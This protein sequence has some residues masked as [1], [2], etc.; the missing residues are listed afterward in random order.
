[1]TKKS[2]YPLRSPA[3]RAR[4]IAMLVDGRAPVDVAKA[5]RVSREA[6][7]QFAQRHAAEIEQLQA[8][9]VAAV[10]DATITQQAERIRRRDAHYAEL[11]KIV[12]WR[13]AAGYASGFLARELKSVTV[14]DER[15]GKGGDVQREEQEVWKT[16]KALADALG[17]ELR[18]VAEELGQIQKPGININTGDTYNVALVNLEQYSPEQRTAL[19]RLAAGRA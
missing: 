5:F 8:K 3:T 4:V 2:R 15:E 19:L 12:E 6:I 18:E 1:M 11:W 9:V 16:D 13:R 14:Y 7:R 17:N 10:E